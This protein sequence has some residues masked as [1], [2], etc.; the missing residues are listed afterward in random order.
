MTTTTE[1]KP[2][3]MQHLS[4]IERRIIRKLVKTI[5]EAGYII[6]VRDEEDVVQDYT[7]DRNEIL[8]AIGHTDM[9]TL[10]V[11]PVDPLGR[12][13]F[14]SLVHG[15]DNDVISDYGMSIAELVRP[16]EILADELDY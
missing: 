2:I 11:R 13:S 3:A 14:I 9:T 8:H 10:V 12:P 1:A 5:L 16:A 6:K 7:C 4:E 15:N